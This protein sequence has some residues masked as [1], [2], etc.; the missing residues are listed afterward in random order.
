MSLEKLKSRDCIMH[1]RINQHLLIQQSVSK[2]KKRDYSISVRYGWAI[3]WCGMDEG[4]PCGDENEL[5]RSCQKAKLHVTCP[6]TGL[7][8]AEQCPFGT[9]DTPCWVMLWSRS[10][11]NVLRFTLLDGKVVDT[12][13]TLWVDGIDSELPDWAG[14]NSDCGNGC[15]SVDAIDSICPTS[16]EDCVYE[17][18]ADNSSPFASYKQS[19]QT[20]TVKLWLTLRMLTSLDRDESRKK[21]LRLKKIISRRGPKIFARTDVGI[22]VSANEMR[23]LCSLPAVDARR[24]TS[25]LPW[26]PATLLVSDYPSRPRPIPLVLPSVPQSAQFDS[27]RASALVDWSVIKPAPQ[28]SK[29]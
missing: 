12:E 19:R 23:C 9:V 13:G 1:K 29:I 7:E 18:P 11:I 22:E 20:V 27:S 15:W 14:V 17:V 4:E 6:I 21:I 8:H 26:P 5:H 3:W 25:R 2:I 24:F 16:P 10:S 28:W